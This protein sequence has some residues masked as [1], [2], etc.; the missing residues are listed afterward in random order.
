MV[1][2]SKWAWVYARSVGLAAAAIVADSTKH[3]TSP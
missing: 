3:V 1:L 2:L